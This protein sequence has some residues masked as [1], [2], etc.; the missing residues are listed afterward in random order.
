MWNPFK[1]SEELEDSHVFD[2]LEAKDKMV[3]DSTPEAKK[4]LKKSKNLSSQVGLEV[5][6]G[7]TI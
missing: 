4:R 5:E 2:S 7:G 6:I 3:V 1:R